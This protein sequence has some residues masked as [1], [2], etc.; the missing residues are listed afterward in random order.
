[1][2]PVHGHHAGQQICGIREIRRRLPFRIGQIGVYNLQLPAGSMFDCAGKS[3][4][5]LETIRRGGL[6]LDDDIF[7]VSPGNQVGR[8]RAQEIG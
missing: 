1:M 3:L 2:N 5:L 8:Q 6:D 7:T 4:D